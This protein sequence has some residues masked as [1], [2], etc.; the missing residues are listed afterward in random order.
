[1]SAKVT[2]LHCYGLIMT[3]LETSVRSLTEPVGALGGMWMLAPEVLAPCRDVGYPNGYAYYVTG[4]GGVL[5]DVDAGVVASAFGFFESQLVR[6]MWEA[7][8]AVEGAR[9]SAHRYGEACA[10]YGRTRAHGFAGIERLATLTEQVALNVDAAGLAL[11]AGWRAEPL[12]VDA[13]GRACLL[14]HVLRELRGS[15]H[16]LA[17]AASGLWPRDAVLATGGPDH[18]KQFGWPEPYPELAAGAK[19]ASEALT[20]A[21]LIRL[22]GAVVSDDE[23]AELAE[24][25]AG[26]RAHVI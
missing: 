17:V 19:D 4:R 23:A 16:V 15:V 12:P 3:T 25:V 6:K 8:V 21:V 26:L 22:Y 11:F 24:L 2:L 5:G 18:A 9:A 10:Q 7:G 1:V 13:A 20:D 14:L